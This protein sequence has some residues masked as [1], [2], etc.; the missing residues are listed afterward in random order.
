MQKQMV[1]SG[2]EAAWRE[3]DKPQQQPPLEQTV[4]IQ[5]ES[6][7]LHAVRQHRLAS[8]SYTSSHIHAGRQPQPATVSHRET[9]GL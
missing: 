3:A 4:I 2:V 6:A 7:E 9:E 8:H 1:H 5:G